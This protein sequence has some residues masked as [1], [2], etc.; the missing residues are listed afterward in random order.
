MPVFAVKS[1]AF[2]AI[3]VGVLGLLK[4]NPIWQPGPYKPSQVSARSQPDF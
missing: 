4:I 1:G 3:I 2:F